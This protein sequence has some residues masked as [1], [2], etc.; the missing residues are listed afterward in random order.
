[1]KKI[2]SREYVNDCTELVV[3]YSSFFRTYRRV[4]RLKGG[5]IMRY[6]G[7]N[8]YMQLSLTEY[9]DVR[10]LYFMPCK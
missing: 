2:I 1:M 9:H 10:A 7:D 5:R 6:C 3:E 4:Y 8:R